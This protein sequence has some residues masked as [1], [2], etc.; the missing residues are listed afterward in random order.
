MYEYLRYIESYRFMASTL[1][2]LVVFLPKDRFTLLD[3]SFSNQSPAG[4]ELLYQKG[5]YP[6]SYFDSHSK[7]NEN[8]LPTREFW[9]NSLHG[10]KVTISAEEIQHAE[11]VFTN[12]NCE[13]LGNFHDLYLT[14]DNLQLAC[15]FEEFRRMTYSTYGLDSAH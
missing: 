9:G 13:N 3:L 15:G 2:K 7:F 10:G 6:Y 12:F 14:C 4:L 11:K 1:D 5:H 8:C